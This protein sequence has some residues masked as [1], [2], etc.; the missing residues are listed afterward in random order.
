MPTPIWSPSSERIAS[1]N[2]S[3]FRRF[4]AERWDVPIDGYEAL[5]DLSVTRI[6]DF[7]DATWDY[8]GLV[9]EK[10]DSVV[11]HA[12]SM[13][14]A[15]WFPRGRL[16]FA[17][18]HLQRRDGAPA[19][20]AYAE[21]HPVRTIS[22]QELNESVSRLMSAMRAAGIGPGDRVA[23]CLPNVPEAVIAMLATTGLGAIWSA[24][25]VESGNQSL[26]DRIGQIEPALLFV[27]D[28]YRYGG[29]T[30][31]LS[32]KSAEL[33]ASMPS[34]RRL[35]VVPFLRR[36]PV[37]PEMTAA[38]PWSDFVASATPEPVSFE[39]FPFEHPAFVLYSSGTTGRPKAI[40]HSAGGVLLQTVKSMAL[41]Y[42]LKRDERIFFPTTPGWMVWNVMVAGLACGATLVLY[43]GSPTYP[44][45]DA[46][47]D[48]I[49]RSGAHVV[50]L[51]PPLIDRYVKAGLR[52]RTTHDL[53]SLKCFAS[54]SAPLLTQHYEY[55]YAD[56]KSDLHLMSPAGGTD[57]VGTLVTG[58]PAGPVYAGEIQVRALGMKIEIFDQDGRSTIGQ[59]GE[60]VCT[61]PFPS[62]PLKFYGD[63]DRGRVEEAYFST[64]PGVWRHGD[65]AEITERGGAVIYG[66]ADATLKV[67]GIRIGTAEIYRCL[68]AFKAIKESA[69][70]SFRRDDEDEIIL[71]VVLDDGVA[72]DP[73]L[74]AR[75]KDAVRDM[76]TARHVPDRILQVP[77]LPKSLNGKVSEIAVRDAIH[78]RKIANT[79][80]LQNPECIDALGAMPEFS[81]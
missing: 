67:N 24:C 11:E 72:L 29:K 5:Y 50:R 57:V 48:I 13:L 73:D 7:W 22:W 36:D 8:L 17:E 25:A 6:A 56:I 70:V 31:D 18:N 79:A 58:N 23:A 34:I 20:I 59:P 47:F 49:E 75:M 1:A 63:V 41:H 10:G 37:L 38:T 42:D 45:L 44:R 68:D 78:G 28:G 33:A 30:F 53:G 43:D 19:L 3:A 74:A 40:V 60:L 2:I 35:V 14:D 15:R 27:A 39:R 80:G 12:Q 46:M 9:G 21:E 66:R 64:Y 69:A 77:A 51:V 32:A 54:G 52:P 26:L 61:A 16:N 71:F 62:V 76:A 81:R 4:V 65:W 55:V